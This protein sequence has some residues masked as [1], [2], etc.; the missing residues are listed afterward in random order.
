MPLSLVPAE[1]RVACPRRQKEASAGSAAPSSAPT[2]SAPRPATIDA[3][4]REMSVEEHRQGF[5]TFVVGMLADFD[6]YLEDGDVDVGRTWW[7]TARLPSI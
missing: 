4:A 7:G 1:R 5:L 2:R 3:E 6:R